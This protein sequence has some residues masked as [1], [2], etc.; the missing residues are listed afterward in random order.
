MASK[1][2]ELRAATMVAWMVLHSAALLAVMK[3]ANL[4]EVWAGQR[5]A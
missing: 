1:L 3:V 4:A 5:G 2:D